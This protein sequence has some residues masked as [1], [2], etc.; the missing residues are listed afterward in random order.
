LTL[1]AAAGQRNRQLFRLARALKGLPRY[2]GAPA[3]ALEPVV[4]GWWRL[5]LPAIRTKAWGE[6][7]ADFRTAWVR[8]RH[9]DDAGLRSG[10]RAWLLEVVPPGNPADDAEGHLLRLEL[11][12]ECLQSR[13]PGRPFPLAARYVEGLLGVS[14]STAHRLIVRLVAAGVLAPEAP[15]DLRRRRGA[16]Y[17][18]RPASL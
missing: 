5:A 13:G 2:T 3:E 9:P 6:T 8:V 15:G 1:P 7:W 4:R 14:K 18:Y 10:L 12:C 11:A 17:R 16:T